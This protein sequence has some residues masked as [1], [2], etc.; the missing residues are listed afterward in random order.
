MGIAPAVVTKPDKPAKRGQQLQ[1]TPVKAAAVKLQLPIHQPEHLSD[2]TFMNYLSAEKPDLI[3]SIAYGE[4]IPSEILRM[5]RLGCIN[6]HPSLLPKYRGAAPVQRALMAGESKT[7]ITLAY[8]T[9]AW[10]AGDILL[11]EPYPIEPDD[12]AGRLLGK[13]GDAGASLIKKAM[14]LIL[15]KKFQATPQVEREATYAPKIKGSETWINWKMSGSE[16]RN[17]IRGLSPEPGARTRFNTSLV[18]IYSARVLPQSGTQGIIID[19]EKDGPVVACG[20]DAI[21][22]TQIQPE[23]RNIMSGKDFMNGYRLQ[24]GQS[25]T[26]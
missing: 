26:G 10:D 8:V 7:G 1:A 17:F 21:V 13:L 18:K 6:L 25:F 9:E 24:K 19:L 2:F 4:F 15:E 23:N 5:P 11:Q 12:D 16:I 14:P 22:L 20:N 3:L